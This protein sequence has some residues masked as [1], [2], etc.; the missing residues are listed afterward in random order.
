VTAS[1]Q[2]FVGLSNLRLDRSSLVRAWGN[3]GSL[4]PGNEAILRRYEAT[5]M[6]ALSE[7][8]ALVERLPFQ[9]RETLLPAARDGIEQVRL[10]QQ[11][12]WSGIGQPK[13]A[14]PPAFGQ[15][16]YD[17]SV[18]LQETMERIALALESSVRT[19]DPVIVQMLAAKQRAWRMRTDLGE[20]ALVVS[21]IVNGASPPAD[22]RTRWAMLTGAAR[23][24]WLLTQDT[25]AGLDLPAT[26]R[27]TLTETAEAQFAP[28]YLALQ[29]RIITAG[30]AGTRPEMTVEQW[31][32]TTVPTLS[33]VVDAAE[34]ALNV[35]DDAAEHAMAADWRN[36]IWQAAVMVLS[37]L[38]AIGGLLLVTR[39]VT[40][41]LLRLRDATVRLAGGDF[42]AETDLGGRKDEIGSMAQ[43]LAQ[44]RRQATENARM[45]Q[46]QR[47]TR[48]RAEQRQRTIET[49]VQSFETGATGA[50][51]ALD[52]ARTQLGD[53][54]DG[55]LHIA[56]RGAGAVLDAERSASEA[57]DNVSGIAAATE[58]LNASIAEIARQV[59][60]AARVSMRAV[61]ETQQTDE[62]V[63]G[64]AESATRIGEVVSLISNIAAQTNLLALNATIEAARAG[65]AGKGFAVVASEVKS[66]ANQ[67][68]KA[69]E[70]I[71]KQIA[72]V[73]SVTQ[74]AVSAI[75]QIRGTID[76]VNAVATTIAASVEEQGAAMQE[77][78]RNT[79]LAA[80]R[81]RQATGSVS[82][83]TA[84]TEATT[85][86]AVAV[87]Q[88]A[89]LLGQEAGR[90]RAQVDGF[91]ERLRAA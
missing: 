36:V 76:E 53:T 52:E 47:Q 66:L 77:I 4:S 44:F 9:G 3:E 24:Q 46:E 65:E 43:A 10:L 28:E 70:E 1:R 18:K 57:S 89:Q 37:V 48:E 2:I 5:A 54:A 45:E 21:A 15:R 64:L 72:S 73:R 20:A 39:Y 29:E 67:T 11:T 23:A 83:M 61:E 25:I 84:E 40:A 41:P 17:E 68:A 82:A 6:P 8:I 30:I 81:T 33:R 50:L 62:T 22:A 59:A 26:V 55:M 74:D 7:S 49:E 71:G 58:E 31:T 12:F 60:Q 80:E 75:S 13:S 79:Q 35:A 88:A 85:H 38:A 34:A 27:R 19:D 87:R 51:K 42:S 16:Y 90:L 86:S 78:A 69:T 56:E 14:R 32:G 63:R 91:L